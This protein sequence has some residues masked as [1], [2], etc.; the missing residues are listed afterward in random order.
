MPVIGVKSVPGCLV[1]I[2]PSLIGVPVAFWPLPAPHF[3]VGPVLAV[4][5]PEEEPP[6]AATTRRTTAAS[7]P[8]TAAGRFLTEGRPTFPLLG[9]P[10]PVLSYLWCCNEVERDEANRDS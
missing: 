6:H 3:D 4:D 1:T 10:R 7:A 5:P 9:R 8:N 2:A